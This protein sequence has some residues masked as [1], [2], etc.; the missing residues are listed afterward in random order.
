MHTYTQV[1]SVSVMQAGVTCTSFLLTTQLESGDQRK[2]QPGARTHGLRS[3]A[4][5]ETMNRGL[6][7]GSRGWNSALECSPR[8]RAPGRH[9]QAV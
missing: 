8:V 6:T 2:T 7:S 5:T 9:F 3:N 4:Y 1:L